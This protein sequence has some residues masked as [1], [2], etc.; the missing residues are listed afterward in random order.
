MVPSCK[1]FQMEKAV[2]V[3]KI[4]LIGSCKRGSEIFPKFS[5]NEVGILKLIVFPSHPDKT[6]Y[7]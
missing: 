6:E 7:R 3:K 4:S 5:L 1:T 2:M